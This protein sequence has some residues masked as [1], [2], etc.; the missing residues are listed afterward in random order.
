MKVMSVRWVDKGGSWYLKANVYN[1]ALIEKQG[2]L[3]KYWL[4][5]SFIF[6]SFEHSLEEAKQAVEAKLGVRDGAT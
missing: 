2:G 6:Y 4:G 5:D 3:F 1:V